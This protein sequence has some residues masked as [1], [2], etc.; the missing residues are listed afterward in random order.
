M[1]CLISLILSFAVLIA[2][3]FIYGAVVE[4]VFA[5]DDRETPAY[6][7]QDGVDFLPMPTW[8]A[9]LVQLLNIAGTGPIFGA[10]MGACF[11]PVVFLWIIFGSV[12]GGGVH[13]YMSGMI[14][15]R[16]DGASIAELSGIYLGKGAKWGMRIFSILLLVLTGTVF[17]TSPAALLARLTPDTLN[18]TFWIIVILVYYVL[19]TLLPIDK[20]IGR[21]Y[22]LFGAV[23][24][25]MAA[26][27]LGGII[28]GG[29]TVPELTLRN[30][31]PAG[32]PVWPF[33]FVT[34]ACGA[35]SGFHA[36]QSPMVAKCIRSEK[37]GRKV[38]YGAM[39]SES[40]IALVWAAGGVAFYGATGGL[41]NALS[42]LGQSGAVYDISTG[43]LGP[44]GGLLAIVG[45][46][47]CPITS[48]DTAFRS[49][50]LILAE[51]TKLD[52]KHIL[53]RL[54][55]TL[56]LLGVGAVL[57]QLDFNVLW[58][59]FSWS[60]QTL[61]M[62]SLWVA[63]AYLLKTHAR[64]RASLL[65]AIPATFMSAVSMTYILMANEGFGLSARIGYPAG[66]VFAAALFAVYII[67]GRKAETSAA[68]DIRHTGGN[69]NMK[70]HDHK[71]MPSI[72]CAVTLVGFLVCVVVLVWRGM[73]Q[74][75][76]WLFLLVCVYYGLVLYYG[77]KGYHKPHGNMV[78]WLILV[79][80][81]FVAGSVLTQIERFSAAW[82]II[83]SNDLAIL[84]MGF[85]AGRLH[86]VEKN[87]Y[88]TIFVSLMLLIRCFWFLE[89]P[90]MSGADAVLFVLDRCQPIFMWLTLL[91]IYFYRYA[92]HKEAGLMVD[93]GK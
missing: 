49:A 67:L 20:V 91:L 29:Y 14:S 39:L 6:A 15:E 44:V 63:T 65:T 86:K 17:V 24:I 59:Y 82:P 41:Q 34:V 80:A 13:D 8:K 18:G 35:I 7:K 21:L 38:F 37:L 46:V 87:K 70:E 48:G 33:M 85:L 62:I 84:A 56:P 42:S 9:F 1:L 57:T 19:A 90:G 52:Q 78:R 76:D 28:A 45:V 10:L 54:I 69:T 58:R 51:I 81:V 36:T 53:N 12:L 50:R 30:L 47:V 72:I 23:L 11:G 27:I 60:N 26:G 31:H 89:H 73:H 68:P 4:K 5:P 3:Y 25:L 40:V 43:M 22:P 83:L 71:K 75:S 92:E 32:L 61:A 2:G 74:E 16:H 88:I 79:L 64:R 66:C 77:V 93:D 55:I